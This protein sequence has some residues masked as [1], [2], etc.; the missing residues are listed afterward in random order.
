MKAIESRRWRHGASGPDAPRREHGSAVVSALMLAALVAAI[1][2]TLLVAQETWIAQQGHLRDR[3]TAR[4]LIHTALHWGRAILHDDRARGE[5]DHLGEA[6]A[7]TLPPVDFEG[8]R[9]S[10]QI[11]DAQARFNLNSLARVGRP[12]NDAIAAYE[13]LLDHLGLPKILAQ[14]AA[15][16]IDSDSDTRV[17]GGAENEYYLALPNPRRAADAPLIDIDELLWVRGYTPAIIAR[18]RPHVVALPS[19][20]TINVN[21]ATVEVL[22]AS[23]GLSLAEIRQFVVMRESAPVTKVA[24]LPVRLPA[25]PLVARAPLGVGSRY[26]LVQGRVRKGAV[27]LGLTALLDRN[28]AGTAWPLI[29]WQRLE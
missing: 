8:A 6:W 25:G 5:V 21:T 9:I 23:T 18:L 14:A 24:D 17:P 19:V 3:Q 20:E 7:Q 11:D 29:T 27:R 12:E 28:T 16:W 10:G 22:A 26:F 4:E 1:G 15:D 2:A 13:R